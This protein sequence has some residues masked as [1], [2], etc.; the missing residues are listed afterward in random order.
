[1]PGK[2]TTNNVTNQT[3]TNAPPEWALPGLEQL[4]SRITS[5]I[6]NM[7]GPAYTG[8]FVAPPN[9]TQYSALPIFANASNMALQGADQAGQA[10]SALTSGGPNYGAWNTPRFDTTAAAMA[11]SQ[12]IFRQLQQQVLPGLQSSALASGAYGGG[13]A[14]ELLPGM[15][16]RDAV[17]GA[18]EIG[19]NMAF[20][21][22]QGAMQDQLAGYQALTQRGLGT[23]GLRQ[24]A[25]LGLPSLL[26]AR[27][28]M[29]TGAGD[30]LSQSG[31]M[32]QAWDQSAIN[33]QLARFQYN[34]DYP[35]QGLD[36]AAQ[37]LSG[38]ASGYGTQTM[39]GTTKTTES[40][41]GL[42]PWLGGA[43][44]LASTLAGMPGIGSALGLGGAAGGAAA[45]AMSSPALASIFTSPG[46]FAPMQSFNPLQFAYRPGG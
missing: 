40:S 8:D 27:M 12:P 1:M 2:K 14:M 21:E 42:A 46:M 35:F 38:L 34:Q 4:A 13:R 26:D 17:R 7:P 3:Q 10:A 25:L 37:L 30:I 19:T 32:Q 23:E 18:Q 45:G 22:H 15:A 43:I 11:A 20:A 36:R 29:A 6:P 39:H 41:G 24:Q 16:I 9:A 33:N 5:I 28:R 31:S 44:G